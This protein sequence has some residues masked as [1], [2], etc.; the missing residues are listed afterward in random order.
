[1]IKLP[2]FGILDLQFCNYRQDIEI[3][4]EM[5]HLDL[6]I[7]DVQMSE[8]IFSKLEYFL[9][10]LQ[11]FNIQNLDYI[12]NDFYSGVGCVREYIK[13]HKRE[14]EENSFSLLDLN[15]TLNGGEILLS[16][17]SLLRIGIYI[18]KINRSDNFAYFDYCIKNE[19]DYLIVVTT[20]ENGH[21]NNLSWES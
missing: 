9:N 11:I 10:R 3:N 18:D 7:A 6:N 2:Y 20:N 15:N 21:I 5:I 19:T 12:N 17:I 8:E 13:Y 16:K 1:M 4:G 14:L